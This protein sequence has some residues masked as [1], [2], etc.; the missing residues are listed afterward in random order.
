MKRCKTLVVWCFTLAAAGG[1]MSAMAQNYMSLHGSY[2]AADEVEFRTAPG[3]VATDFDDGY[4]FGAALGARLGQRGAAGRWRVE[5][6]LSF[7]TND[8]ESHRLN[9]GAP[10]AGPT[11]ELESMSVMLNAL[12]DFGTGGRLTPYLGA[13]IGV[14]KVEASG[15]GTAASP[16]VL[17]DEDTVLAY[18][19]IAG[20][21]YDISPNAE[22]FAEYRWF[23]TDDPQMRTSVA[24]GR[25]PTSI[26][27]QSNRFLAGLRF[28]L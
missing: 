22:L 15:F 1:S 6:E 10:L 20:A 28:N 21:G 9:G 4:G 18:Q 14:A 26:E 11:G 2:V 3:R 13:G 24:T 5:G 8:A 19:L 7:T 25:V 27:Y 16:A 23:A 12:L 17:D